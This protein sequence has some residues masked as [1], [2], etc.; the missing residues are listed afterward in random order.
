MRVGIPLVIFKTVK[1]DASD[2]AFAI[3]FEEECN[4]NNHG[5]LGHNT[6]DRVIYR[7]LE[8][9]A[10]RERLVRVICAGGVVFPVVVGDD[11]AVSDSV[12]GCLSLGRAWAPA[13]QEEG[14]HSLF[15]KRGSP[16]RRQL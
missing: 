6:W 9:K 10:H 16:K 11:A 12:W 3:G 4:E 15:D 7:P 8:S 5:S 13:W 2:H 14:A 1:F